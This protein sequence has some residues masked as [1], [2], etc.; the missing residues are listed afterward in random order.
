[1]TSAYPFSFT[2]RQG[3]PYVLIGAGATMG[4]YTAHDNDVQ[5]LSRIAQ[6][7]MA[8]ETTALRQKVLD[9]LD[10]SSGRKPPEKYA[11][12]V[13]WNGHRDAVH[14][15]TLVGP[16][17]RST[18]AHAVLRQWQLDQVVVRHKDT[19]R[20][21]GPRLAEWCAARLIVLSKIE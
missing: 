15:A 11:H 14:E 13:R 19:C 12:L 10:C 6:R 21:L 17:A 4:L 2:S 16:P 5:W 3:F 20:L 1:M 9:V 8:W 18:T 7:G